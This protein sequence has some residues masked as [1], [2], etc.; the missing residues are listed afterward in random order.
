MPYYRLAQRLAEENRIALQVK[1]MIAGGNNAG[2]IHKSAG[3]VRTAA[4]SVPCRYLHA[5]ISM[6]ATEDYEAEQAM[7]T[8]LA[9]AM[10]A[11]EEEI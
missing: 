6:I 1:Q 2:V 3:G 7:L 9:A 8:K 5:P 10:A 4:L 11:G